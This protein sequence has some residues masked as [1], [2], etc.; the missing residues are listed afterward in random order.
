MPVQ[1]VQGNRY[2]MYIER[3]EYTGDRHCSRFF[4]RKSPLLI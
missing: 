2:Y 1:Y 3:K 4:Y